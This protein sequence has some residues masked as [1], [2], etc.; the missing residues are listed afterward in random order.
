L[1]DNVP[2]SILPLI[3]PVVLA[4]FFAAARVPV[5]AQVTIVRGRIATV[6]PTHRRITIIPDEATARIE[7]FLDKDGSIRRDDRPLSLRDLV[8]ETGRRVEIRYRSDGL[9]RLAQTITVESSDR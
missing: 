4:F 1:K 9:R 3:L 5:G 8:L 2:R 7:L 6:E